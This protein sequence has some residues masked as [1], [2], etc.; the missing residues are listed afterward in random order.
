MVHDFHLIRLD[1]CAQ[2]VGSNENKWDSFSTKSI[3]KLPFL[4]LGLSLVALSPRGMDQAKP[5]LMHI[6]FKFG[7]A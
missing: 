3:R 1:L 6:A 7:H 2:H 4:T 5:Q